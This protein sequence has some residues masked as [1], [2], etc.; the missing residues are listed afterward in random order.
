MLPS[1]VQARDRRR[2]RHRVPDGR[3][4]EQ[5]DMDGVPAPDDGFSFGATADAIERARSGRAL[6]R[7]TRVD[8]ILQESAHLGGDH[9]EA[10]MVLCERVRLGDVVEGVGTQDL[11]PK[12]VEHLGIGEQT[13]F[14]DEKL[15]KLVGKRLQLPGQ[16]NLSLATATEPSDLQGSYLS[17]VNDTRQD[18]ADAI[19]AA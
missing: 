8:G 12:A 11:V 16:S 17:L 1:P 4:A 18:L 19:L 3:G 5:S 14:E 6:L 10:P 9:P 15:E 2:C 13:I 7:V